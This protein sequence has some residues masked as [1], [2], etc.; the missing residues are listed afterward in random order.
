MRVACAFGISC[1][2]A[3]A[4]AGCGGKILRENVLATTQST[5]GVSLAQNAQT[6][7]YELKAGFFRNEFFLVPTSKRVVNNADNKDAAG[8]TDN[9]SV[10]QQLAAIEENDPSSTPEVLAEIQVGGSGKQSFKEQSSNVQVYQRLA[11]GKVA[12]QSKAA[13]ALMANDAATASVLAGSATS[14]AEAGFRLASIEHI[15]N[16]LDEMKARDPKAGPLLDRLNSAARRIKPP[17]PSF[18]RY[19]DQLSDTPP[20]LGK[21]ERAAT[22]AEAFADLSD[23]IL[24]AKDLSSSVD[25]LR[26]AEAKNAALTVQDRAA[27]PITSSTMSKS[28]ISSALRDQQAL[29]ATLGVAINQTAEIREAIEYVFGLSASK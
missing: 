8:T 24:Y 20:A 13:V 17:A 25:A 7:M 16:A 19:I 10:V 5:I 28:E 11:V 18:V 9:H 23:M 27:N 14:G 2:V 29:A 21:R 4:L 15:K 6:Q 26:S 3:A 22:S 1:A 12:V